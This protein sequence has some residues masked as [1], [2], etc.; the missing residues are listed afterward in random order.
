MLRCEE[1]KEGT[2]SKTLK[3]KLQSWVVILSHNSKEERVGIRTRN[4]SYFRLLSFCALFDSTVLKLECFPSTSCTDGFCTRCSFPHPFYHIFIHIRVFS[5]SH[6]F[7]IC[8]SR[9]LPPFFFFFCPLTTA[10]AF[11]SF[12]VMNPKG[13][14][15]FSD[16][17]F[18]VS[19]HLLRVSL[20][21]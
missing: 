10:L 4:N 6:L 15:S 13:S 2:T 17:A 14:I 7:V 16:A 3:H 20:P 5:K 9:L 11:F 8:V 12:G 1:E 18:T 21:L 19:Q